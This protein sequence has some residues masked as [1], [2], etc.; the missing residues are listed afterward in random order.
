MLNFDDI[1]KENDK[2]N[3]QMFATFNPVTGEGSILERRHI[4]IEDF[5]IREQWIP[6]SMLNE[7]FV[8]NLV[9]AG[10]VSNFYGTLNEESPLGSNEFDYIVKTFVRLRCKYDF[11]FWSVMYVLISNKL[12]GDDIHFSLNYPQR[13]LI[14]KFEQMRLANKP[15]RLILLKARQWGGSTATQIYMAWLQ[16]VQEEGLNSL[17]VGHVK[18]ASYEVRDMFD[19]MINEYPVGLLH[20]IGEEYD[21]SEP[22]QCAVG[23]SGNIKRIP[24]RNCKIKIGSYEKPESARG[25]AYSLVHC[26]E[27][28]LWTPTDNRSPEKVVRSACS[29]ITL[30]PLTMIVYEST[31]NGTGNFFERE[32]NA[33]KES[34][35]HIRRCEESTSQFCSLFIAWYQIELYRKEFKDESSKLSFA[36]SLYEK[37]NQVYSPTNRAESGRY[38]WYL[39]QSGAT[40]EAIAWYIDERKKY[41]DHG[42]MA[43]EYPT[44]DNE[45]FVYSGCKVFDKLLVERFRAACKQPRY[46][47]DIYG[48]GD[49]GKLA[50]QNVRFKDDKTGLLCV[51]DKPDIDPNERVKDRYLVVVDIGGRSA[52]ADWSVICVFDRMYLMSGE[53]PEVVAQWYGHIDM[54]LLAWKA[55]Q[56]AKWYDD[57]LLVIES[58][59]LETKDR[60]RMVDGEQSQFILYEIKDVYDNLYAR[61]QSE[62]EIREG[63]PKRYGFH[64]NVSTKPMIISNL[65]K[66]I[67][68]HL[69]VERDERCLDEYLTYEQKQNGSFGAIAGKH[70]DLLMTR[71]IGLHI[72][73]NFKVMPLPKVV[74]R[75][76]LT[77]V[78]KHHVGKI[79]EAV[80]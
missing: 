14:T 69:Y 79:T 2:R 35:E 59:T 49:E 71:A 38:L 64:T 31:A 21:I 76:K 66:V 44:D 11:A 4:I 27:V 15:I 46:V 67:R 20:E 73:Y 80:I 51:W 42:D 45:A 9:K 48:D 29:G 68:E 6:K 65:V 3:A 72:A 37:K 50:L 13:I 47:G 40:L 12:G 23:N 1:L 61:E 57:A 43:S 18:D 7:P 78:R 54:D 41:T 36:R 74:S 10:S 62:D 28:G 56:I 55:A 60:E 19:K 39:W 26:T 33:A 53:R 17:I 25:G 58:N 75:N 30:K 8:R 70:D 5:P 77:N 16:L 22:K 52:K 24:Q 34:D 63:A 32:Y